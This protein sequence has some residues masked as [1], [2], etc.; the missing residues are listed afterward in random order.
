MVAKSKTSSA[1]QAPKTGKRR[2]G[3]IARRRPSQAEAEEAIRT[4]IRWAGDE[5]TR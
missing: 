4:L 2:V 3:I 1:A 5:P